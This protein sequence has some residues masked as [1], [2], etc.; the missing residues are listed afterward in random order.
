M[1]TNHPGMICRGDRDRLDI[2]GYMPLELVIQIVEY[3][4]QADIVR[5]QRVPHCQCIDFLSNV[6]A[7]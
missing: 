2:V 3:L 7:S 5:F 4:D 6:L 1:E